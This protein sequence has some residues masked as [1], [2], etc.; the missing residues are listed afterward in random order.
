MEIAKSTSSSGRRG[1][2]RAFDVDQ[3]VDAALTLLDEGGSAGLSVRAVAGR[4]GVNPNAVYTYVPDREAL[5]RAVVERLLAE[6]DAGIE[7]QAHPVDFSRSRTWRADLLA[8]AGRL[9]SVL[10]RHPGAA[11]LF[12]TAPMNG[13]HA[14]AIGEHL[15]ET[16]A[17][18]GLSGDDAARATY[19][20]IV[21]VLGAVA[22]EVAE[23]DGRA[24][25]PTEEVRVAQ[26]RKA[27]GSTD[28]AHYPRTAA[29]VAVMAGWI[30]SEQFEW[31]LGRLLDGLVSV[32]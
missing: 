32:P 26:R 21:Y 6:A 12:M 1:P 30:G 25:L 29:T 3:I 16:F 23:T 13:P 7:S 24:P 18:A 2:R 8:Y 19:A 4:L 5:E 9:R 31:G 28:S 10:L 27:L 15:L 17:A 22:L 14:M 20:V 11:P